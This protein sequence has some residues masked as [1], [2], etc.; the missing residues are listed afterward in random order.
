MDDWAEAIRNPKPIDKSVDRV[1][2]ERLRVLRSA[3][4]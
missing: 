4:Y 2:V 3:M 1:L